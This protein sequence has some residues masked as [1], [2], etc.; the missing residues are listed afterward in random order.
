MGGLSDIGVAAKDAFIFSASAVVSW[1]DDFGGAIERAV[2]K[3]GT[4]A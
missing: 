1:P 2:S 3:L 4:D